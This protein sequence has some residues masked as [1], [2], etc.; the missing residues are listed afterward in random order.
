MK[1]CRF[2]WLI[3]PLALASP[4]LA[5]IEVELRFDSP[6]YLKYEPIM[7]HV[8]ISNLAG[9]TIGLFNHNDKP[10]LSFYVSRRSGEQVDEMGVEYDLQQAQIA[11][12]D[13][14]TMH[15]NL[16][17]VYNIRSPGVYRV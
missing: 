2:P 6:V 17:P 8:K 15:V 7:A 9:Y 13:T 10:W 16:T 3:L 1:F 11:G 14:L 5:Q 12:G 4:V